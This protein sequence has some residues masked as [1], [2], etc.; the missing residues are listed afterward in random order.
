ML[1]FI[2][3]GGAFT[4]KLGNCSAYY[5]LT[6]NSLV[7][8]D[9]GETVF[10][11]ILKNNLLSG[12]DNLYII[13]THTHSDHIGSLGSLLFYSDALNIKSVNVIYPDYLKMELVINLFGVHKTNT[14]ILLPEDITNF[15][16]K[17]YKL[18]HS[19]MEAYGYLFSHN[20]KTLYYSGDTKN[21]PD[22]IR[23]KIINNE[24]DYVYHDVRDKANSYHISLEELASV[25]PEEYRYKVWCMHMPDDMDKQLVKKYGFNIAKRNIGR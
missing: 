9:C 6:N 14:N 25:I 2:G 3:I 22:D 16:L 4:K 5:K 15:I 19:Y 23:K 8:F 18:E 13:I 1:N 17:P 11:E 12:I 10:T 24:I 7:L 20:N 21:L